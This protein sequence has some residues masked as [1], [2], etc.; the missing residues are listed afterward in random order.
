MS[1]YLSNI[2]LDFEKFSYNR[3]LFLDSKYIT[4]INIQQANWYQLLYGISSF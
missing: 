2:R 4:W 1:R 3:F